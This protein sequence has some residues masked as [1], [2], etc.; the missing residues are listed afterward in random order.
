MLE[1]DNFVGLK[2][3]NEV[4]VVAPECH[5]PPR[6]LIRQRI[7][8]LV[9]LVGHCVSSSEHYASLCR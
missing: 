9:E 7:T 8:N 2:N 5:S 4:F 6:R 1:H 3:D